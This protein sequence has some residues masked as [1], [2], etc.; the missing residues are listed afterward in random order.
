MSAPESARTDVGGEFDLAQW[1]K[2]NGRSATITAAVAALVAL[3]VWLYA[4]SQARKEAFASQALMQARG[5]AE[6]GNLP[7][8]ATDLSRLV[9]RFGGTHAADQAVI[10]LNQTRL[11]QGQR[12]VAINAL[13]QYVS[14][15]HP[16]F[17]KASAYAL[18]GGALEDAGKSH[19]AAEAFR[20]A[21]Q[22]ARLDFLR[23]QYLIDAARSFTSAGD[24]ATARTTYTE[25]LTKYGRL[26][27]AAEARVR[28]A[29][30]GGVVPPLPPPADSAK[31]S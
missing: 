2:D 9:E 30:I 21:A 11:V 26:D 5:E 14:R 22:S 17:V 1:I 29:E 4:S 6:S 28:M 31:A 8:A 23:A 16:D 25:V 19:E 12:D 3:G 7:L 27:Q 24:T 20:N 15:S 10:L 13:R 18:L